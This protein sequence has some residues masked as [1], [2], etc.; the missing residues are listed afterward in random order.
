ML[1]RMMKMN[2][3]L[4]II[5][6]KK[7]DKVKRKTLEI[8]NSE[9]PVIKA[10]R[11]VNSQEIELSFNGEKTKIRISVN[12]FK[13]FI[14]DGESLYTAEKNTCYI[15]KELSEDARATLEQIEEFLKN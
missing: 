5:W 12:Q 2:F 15:F 13:K 10:F 14:D 4:M 9:G 7:M 6:I 1:P 11:R 8:Y 3:P